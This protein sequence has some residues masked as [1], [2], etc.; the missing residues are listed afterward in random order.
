MRSPQITTQMRG[1]YT[2]ITAR[3]QV[4]SHEPEIVRYI[5]ISGRYY[6]VSTTRTGIDGIVS[7][8][9]TLAMAERRALA[10]VEAQFRADQREAKKRATLYG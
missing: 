2:E 8:H 5:I 1:T 10:G 9:K 4:N 3:A 7:R 6:Y